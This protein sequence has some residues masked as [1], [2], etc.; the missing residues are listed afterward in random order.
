MRLRPGAANCRTVARQYMGELIEDKG[1]YSRFICTGQLPVFGD[2]N[3]LFLVQGGHLSHGKCYEPYFHYKGE[4]H[5]DLPAISAISQ[6]AS[7]QNAKACI[8]G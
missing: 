2:K 1:Y 6:V 5:G 3:I 4:G 7:A 8:F